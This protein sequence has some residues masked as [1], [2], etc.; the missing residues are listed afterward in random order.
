MLVESN[1]ILISV[2]ILFAAGGLIILLSSFFIAKDTRKTIWQHYLS[3]IIIIALFLLAYLID[4]QLLKLVLLLFF[5]RIV[6]ELAYLGCWQNNLFSYALVLFITLV[7][8][9]ALIDFAEH[10]QFMLI[11]VWVYM[12]TESNDAFAYII[13]KSFGKHPIA[14]KLSPGKTWEGT[15]GGIFFALIAAFV[16]SFMLPHHLPI[17]LMTLLVLVSGLTGDYFISWL[18]RK[19]RQKDFKALFPQGGLLDIYDALIFSTVS[20]WLFLVLLEI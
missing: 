4:L 15:L 8:T 10:P 2:A 14:P 16:F 6:Y 1:T 9:R 5:F 7:F 13:G 12:V 19:N 20:I 3:E 17:M 18:K 11:P